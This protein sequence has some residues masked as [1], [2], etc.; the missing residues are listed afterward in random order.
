MSN[1]IHCSESS[2][3]CVTSAPL[4]YYITHNIMHVHIR[5]GSVW[6]SLSLFTL[7]DQKLFIHSLLF[8]C[9]VFSGSS[10]RSLTSCSRASLVPTSSGTHPLKWWTVSGV[11]WMETSCWRGREVVCMRVFAL[12]LHCTFC[13]M[14]WISD[15]VVY[16][17]VYS[18][19][20][21][22]L[23]AWSLH[24]RGC[25]VF[26]H[27]DLKERVLCEHSQH[28]RKA[29]SNRGRWATEAS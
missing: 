26:F 8:V 10:C 4:K 2:V 12:E 15:E 18:K 21:V 14:R 25:A 11:Q 6:H 3:L 20:H 27:S 17:L 23:S 13:S 28:Y 24:N 29:H 7:A 22:K 5:I 1:S 16:E 9:A 19:S